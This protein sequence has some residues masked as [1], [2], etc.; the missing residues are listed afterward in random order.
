[1]KYLLS[2][3]VI[4]LLLSCKS[5]D[6]DYVDYYREIIVADSIFRL[7]NDTLKAI[8]IQKKVF[9]KFA[10]RQTQYLEEYENYIRFSDRYNRKFGGKKSLNRLIH[11]IAPNWKYKKYDTAFIAF[12]KKHGIDSITIEEKLKPGKITSTGN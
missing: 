12:Y 8:R 1:M 4:I 9:R 5:Q 7:Q 3:S 6:K 10:P 11:L 2:F